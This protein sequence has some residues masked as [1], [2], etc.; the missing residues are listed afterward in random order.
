MPGDP[1]LLL[2]GASVRAAAFSALRAGLRPW[3]I[4]LFADED[5]RARCE[6]RALPAGHYPEGLSDIFAGGPPG[7]WMYTGA[8]ENRPRLVQALSRE[9]TLWGNSAS[10]LRRVRSPA[11]VASLLGK[12]GLAC[13]RV[14]RQPPADV[15]I[16]WLVKPLAGA[17]GRAIRTWD[18]RGKKTWRRGVYLQE[19]VEGESCAALYVGDSRSAR[20]LGVTWQLV[21][22][23]WL[24]AKRFQYCGSIGPLPPAPAFAALGEVLCGGFGLRGLFGVDCV[25]R[26]GVPLPVEVNPRYT[27][28]AEVLELTTGQPFLADHRAVFEPDAPLPPG[29]AAAAV[30]GKAV[31]YAPRDLLFPADGPWC[32]ALRRPGD[33]WEVPRFADLP[34]AGTPV[35][36]G[37]PVLTFFAEANSVAACREE[38]CRGAASLTS[39]LCR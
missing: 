36:A 30:L 18:R 28:S 33:L 39:L 34:A 29:R 23:A 27:A 2:A 12:A 3:C 1:H 10:V 9:R 19:Y 13:P 11:T 26:D 31:L 35:A 24:H 15:G 17:G 8:L 21:G 20:L 22:E 6:A 25:M 4:D 37:R 7:P 16:E 14:R 32:D 5:L 38:L